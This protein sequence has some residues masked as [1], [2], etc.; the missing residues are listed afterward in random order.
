MSLCLLLNVTTC[1]PVR[2]T[3]QQLIDYV[4]ENTDHV[5][6]TQLVINSGY[7]YDNGKPQFVDFY[8][9]LLKAKEQLDPSYVSKQE[10]EDAQYE[11]LDTDT[12]DLYDAV[13]DRL[14]E[15]WDHE[16]IMEFIDEL[17]D[18]GITTFS[19]FEDAFC[20]E[21]DGYWAEKEF[22]EYWVCEVMCEAPSETIAHAVDWQ[23]VW[24]HNLRYDFNTIETSNGTFFF[25]NN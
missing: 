24:D 22:A 5:S 18:L 23:Q 15:K 14:G 12:K 11:E 10:A 4:N 9:E 7:V 17:D 25:W 6:R 3:G 2:Y 21:S 20:Y 13:H 16:E 1:A 8:T 19:E